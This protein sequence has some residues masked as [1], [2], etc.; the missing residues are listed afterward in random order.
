MRMSSIGFLVAGVLLAGAI[1]PVR[2]QSLADVAKK[3][4]ERRRHVKTGKVYTNTDLAPAKDSSATADAASSSSTAADG[5]GAAA[6]DAATKS[7]G[8]KAAKNDEQGEGY[9]SKRMA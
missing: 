1:A 4:E 2:A 7:D 8:T 3:E 5:S 6:P 9:W